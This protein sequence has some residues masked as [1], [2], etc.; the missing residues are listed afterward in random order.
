MSKFSEND[1]KRE[2]PIV[3]LI[4]KKSGKDGDAPNKEQMKTAIDKY[5]DALDEFVEQ[6]IG[7]R[8]LNTD[9]LR[10]L[11]FD[12]DE[13]EAAGD[14]LTPEEIKKHI[15][16]AVKF[17]EFSAFLYDKMVEEKI[18][19][20]ADSAMEGSDS[21]DLDALRGLPEE[22]KK[23]K[24]RSIIDKLGSEAEYQFFENKQNN[25]DAFL[26]AFF[27]VNWRDR[28]GYGSYDRVDKNKEKSGHQI[29][30]QTIKESIGGENQSM[31]AL[32]SLQKAI[33]AE[34]GAEGPFAAADYKKL[35]AMGNEEFRTYI[36]SKDG[37]EAWTQA[38]NGAHKGKA[39]GR[40]SAW[41]SGSSGD[42]E[43]RASKS[44]LEVSKKAAL[45][46]N[47][48]KDGNYGMTQEAL[49]YLFTR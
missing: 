38:F 39:L 29:G 49:A 25:L 40:L 3:D 36:T 16:E 12:E 15:R 7:G 14:Q 45:Q 32:I 27:D 11:G 34:L 2:T 41:V 10:D 35:L 18:E 46:Q 47:L 30:A 20:I 19:E 23:S 26:D 17:D 33:I 42:N 43:Y 13:I 9:L 4:H 44:M 5:G 37:T 6:Q 1:G 28:S 8:E 48:P 24:I 22:E 31:D 21:A